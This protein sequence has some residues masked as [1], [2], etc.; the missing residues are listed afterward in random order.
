MDK[1]L[2]D[3]HRERVRQEFFEKGIPLTS[4]PHKVLEMILFYCIPKGDVTK[5]AY[6]LI[7]AYGSLNAVFNAPREELVKFKGITDKSVMLFKM[8]APVTAYCEAESCGNKFEF[9]D[10]NRMGQ[11]IFSKFYGLKKEKMGILLMD[12]FYRNL[13]FEFVSEGDFNQTAVPIS[14]IVKLALNRNASAVVI[15]HNHPT[16]YALPSAADAEATQRLRDALAYV[17]IRL[18]D[19]IIIEENDYVSMKYSQEYTHLFK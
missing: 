15:A 10:P 14:T 1:G 17:G 2:H 18:Y 3:G 8:F 16:G 13:G 7:E 4:R 9:R 12:G 6:D 19:H 5:Y 11:Y